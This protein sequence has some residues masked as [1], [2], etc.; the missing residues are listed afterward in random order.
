MSAYWVR[1]AERPS[2]GCYRGSRYVAAGTD[3]TSAYRGT[4][5]HQW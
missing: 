1:D 3:A 5:R 4:D 2:L